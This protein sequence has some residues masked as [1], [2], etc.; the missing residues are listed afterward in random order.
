MPGNGKDN[1]P[2]SNVNG[3]GFRPI[4]RYADVLL[5]YAEAANMA[6]GGPSQAAYDAINAV[7]P[8]SWFSR[9]AFRDVAK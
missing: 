8:K 5:V 9:L 7:R 3:E 1:P 6:E 4:L 2:G